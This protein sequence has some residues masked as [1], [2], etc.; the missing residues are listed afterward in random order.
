[1]GRLG[2]TEI[3]LIFFI[4]GIMMIPQIFYL[5]TLQKTI[6][7]VSIEN[8]KI[9]PNQVW[10]SLIPLFGLIWQFIMVNRIGISLKAEFKKRN[11]SINEEKPGYNSGLIYCILFCCSIIPV[12]GIFAG[13]GGFV[14]WIIYWVKINNFKK[15]LETRENIENI[16]IE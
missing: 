6:K 2:G 14:F 7:E 1:M 13:I 15:E 4:F 10:L 5:I 16:G 12:L 8:R 3:I 9:Q 11:L